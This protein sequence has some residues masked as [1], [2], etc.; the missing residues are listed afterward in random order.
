MAGM[1]LK[2]GSLNS[3]GINVVFSGVM[4][5][6]YLRVHHVRHFQLDSAT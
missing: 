4:R 2:G 5:I 6:T 3:R 1:T